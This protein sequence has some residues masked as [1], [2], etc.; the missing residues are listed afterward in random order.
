MC[1][2]CDTTNVVP[3]CDISIGYRATCNR[4]V[5]FAYPTYDTTNVH[6]SVAIFKDGADSC[7]IICSTCNRA[8][9]DSYVTITNDCTNV[10]ATFEVD[11]TCYMAVFDSCACS[12]ANDSGNSCKSIAFNVVNLQ[13]LDRSIIS[14]TE[15]C[16]ALSRMI[17]YCFK[18]GDRIVLTV[19][20]SLEGVCGRTNRCPIFIFKVDISRE[21]NS[22]TCKAVSCIYCIAERLEFFKIID[23]KLCSI[24]RNT[25]SAIAIIF[26]DKALCTECGRITTISTCLNCKFCSINNIE[27]L[28]Y[29]FNSNIF[30]RSNA[31]YVNRS[32]SIA[33]IDNSTIFN[34][35]GNISIDLNK[36]CQ[37]FAVEID[38]NCLRSDNHL[39]NIFPICSN[40]H[41][42]YQCNV[43]KQCDLYIR[44]LCFGTKQFSDK[45]ELAGTIF[46]C[47][48]INFDSNNGSFCFTIISQVAK[49]AVVV[50][51]IVGVTNDIIA[52]KLCCSRCTTCCIIAVPE[53][54]GNVN[55]CIC[56]DITVSSNNIVCKCKF[57]ILMHIYCTC[58]I[59]R[60]AGYINL[61]TRGACINTPCSTVKFTICNCN[62]ICHSYRYAL[63]KRTL[64][65]YIFKSTAIFHIERRHI[66]SCILKINGKI[67]ECIGNRTSGS[68]R[69]IIPRIIYRIDSNAIAITINCNT[70]L[71]NNRTG[72]ITKVN[73][74]QQ[75][76]GFTSLH[77]ID[78]ICKSF[79]IC[80]VNFCS[81]ILRFNCKFREVSRRN[82]Y[83]LRIAFALDLIDAHKFAVVVNVSICFSYTCG[84]GKSKGNSLCRFN[85]C[86]VLHR[87]N[88]KYDFTIN[89]YKFDFK[90]CTRRKVFGS[91]VI[92][93]CVVFNCFNNITR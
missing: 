50:R 18:I 38:Y 21:V 23:I 30:K 44:S 56:F 88:V 8:I 17:V 79:I 60:C 35:S 16:C 32:I 14:L 24:N 28:N 87:S 33:V 29:R 11:R 4:A 7:T 34:S 59:E 39:I 42:I 31:T 48:A 63:T 84:N 9:L 22:N 64:N 68:K 93:R 19:K 86:S 78:C 47:F 85:L 37:S 1:K 66:R 80:I 90:F 12:A 20:C 2:T 53:V 92:E 91:V 40:L 45:S 58:S 72:D 81:K 57:A 71:N 67:L 55:S 69:R 65:C 74:S 83:V 43:I 77:I 73:V 76:D 75:N 3:A 70:L 52:F 49:N 36:A 13:V 41:T 51:S 5:A 27:C 54:F 89:A 15:E 26:N 62:R 10:L 61:N 46:I 82:F 25:I 6:L